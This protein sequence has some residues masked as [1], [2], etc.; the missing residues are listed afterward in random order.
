MKNILWSLNVLSYQ[1]CYMCVKGNKPMKCTPKWLWMEWS[2]DISK[3]R[4]FIILS[5]LK[6][7]STIFT[8]WY[9]HSTTHYWGHISDKGTWP[10]PKQFINLLSSGKI[11]KYDSYC[12]YIIFLCQYLP[13]WFALLVSTT[14]HP[15]TKLYLYLSYLLNYFP[16]HV[17]FYLLNWL[18][19]LVADIPSIPK[20]VDSPLGLNILLYGWVKMG[21]G[22][23]TE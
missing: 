8:I 9:I 5:L 17:I 20:F 1:W 2:L 10:P 16:Y 4:I 15:D 21:I 6:L 14:Q 13:Y 12:I 3:N 7:G 18:T 19:M 22:V 23:A 11:V